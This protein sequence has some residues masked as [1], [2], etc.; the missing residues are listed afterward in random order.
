[1]CWVVTSWYKGGMWTNKCDRLWQLHRM[2]CMN[3]HLSSLLDRCSK[4]QCSKYF[5]CC[6]QFYVNC[7][8]LGPLYV[9]ISDYL[10]SSLKFSCRKLWITTR[11]KMI[12]G[13]R[14]KPFDMDMP[15][16]SVWLIL[17][18]YMCCNYMNILQTDIL[19][20]LFHWINIDL[21]NN[22]W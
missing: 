12:V 4:K 17:C 14:G 8:F 2:L 7:F 11:L 13:Q 5:L 6:I 19:F 21:K 15:L 3:V 10:C 9:G 20:S 16:T 22:P 18:V 1:M